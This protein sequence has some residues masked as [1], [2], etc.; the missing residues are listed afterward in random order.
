MKQP[1]PTEEQEQVA[2]AQWLDLHKICYCHVP[3]G[4]NRNAITG[5]K[6]KAQGV[7]PGVPDILIFDPP[8]EHPH[9]PGTAIELKR[10][11]GGTVSTKQGQWLQDLLDRGWAVS[12]CK[13]AGEAIET[14]RRLGYGR[15]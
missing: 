15:R 12:V 2:L 8:P 5:K 13:G 3:N 11:K 1:I 14:L 4:G 6:L 10:R 7:K 9:M